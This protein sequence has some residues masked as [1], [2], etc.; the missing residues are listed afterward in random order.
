MESS[1]ET[2]WGRPWV[3]LFEFVLILLGTACEREH[4]S[5]P[6]WAKGSSGLQARWSSGEIAICIS[7]PPSDLGLE[8]GEVVA[9]L[10]RGA[11]AWGLERRVA[12]GPCTKRARSAEDGVNMVS[13]VRGQRSSPGDP[14]GRTVLYTRRH[15]AHTSADE[16]IEADVE[17]YV[18]AL[19][20]GR[21]R[22]GP[23]LL[24]AV[25]LHELGHVWGLAHPCS[26]VGARGGDGASPSCVE[27]SRRG[28]SRP[29][30]F[31]MPVS[32]D[33]GVLVARPTPRERDAVLSVYGVPG[34]RR[35]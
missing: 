13:F 14:Y 19:E 17:L 20:A 29:L 12:V 22:F 31:P 33:S 24:E 10:K 3:R 34:E 7:E 16:I 1:R 35:E 18:A 9:L 8:Y 15:P 32:L 5:E 27:P 26:F 30:M 23:S 25:V 6:R 21:E 2:P 11:R 4:V 28:G